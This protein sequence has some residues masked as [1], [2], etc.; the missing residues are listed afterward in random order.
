MC[1]DAFLFPNDFLGR[2][3]CHKEASYKWWCLLWK[4]MEQIRTSATFWE[5]DTEQTN[6]LLDKFDSMAVLCTVVTKIVCP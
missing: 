1:L 6:G 2:S 3:L 4:R 5:T